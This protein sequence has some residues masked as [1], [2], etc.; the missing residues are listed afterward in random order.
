MT[1]YEA[2]AALK[3]LLHE[4]FP[5]LDANALDA[6]RFLYGTRDPQVEFHPGDK[7]LTDFLYGDEFDK[8]MPGRLREAKRPFRRAAATRPCS[9]GQYAP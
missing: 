3:Q 8:D 4:I 5:Y 2:Y 7:T 1:D 9:G 6:A